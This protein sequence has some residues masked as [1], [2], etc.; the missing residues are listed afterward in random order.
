MTETLVFASAV[1]PIEPWRAA[2]EALL[3]DVRV[4][5]PDDIGPG[6]DVRYALV[7]KP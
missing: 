4:R 2:L 7:W 6:D 5:T 1:D 3:P